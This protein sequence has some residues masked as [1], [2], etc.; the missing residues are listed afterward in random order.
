MDNSGPV[1]KN[2]ICKT[3]RSGMLAAFCQHVFWTAE[4][5]G[6]REVL[7]AAKAGW[8]ERE[9]LPAAKAGRIEGE[10]LFAAKSRPDC[11]RSPALLQWTKR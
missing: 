3:C 7:L 5:A 2:C 6:L 4:P 9:I 11:E 1:E 8:I 10:V